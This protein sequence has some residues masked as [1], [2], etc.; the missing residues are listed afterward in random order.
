[1]NLAAPTVKA[2]KAKQSAAE[3]QR[4]YWAVTERDEQA[5]PDRHGCRALDIDPD[6]GP[7]SGR[8]ERHHAGNTIGARRVTAVDRVCLLCEGHH[9]D[10][11]AGVHN[12]VIVEWLRGL[13][14]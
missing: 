3:D 6:A 5:A 12:R 4:V 10:G 7:C 8:I 11:W 2:P 14:S 13:A 1:M 9:Q